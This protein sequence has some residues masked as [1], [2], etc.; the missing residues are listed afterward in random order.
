MHLEGNKCPN[1]GFNN[2][3]LQSNRAMMEI[4]MLNLTNLMQEDPESG[5]LSLGASAAG[6]TAGGGVNLEEPYE[7][8]EEHGADG[9]NLMD[10]ANPSLSAASDV[11]SDDSDSTAAPSWPP[12]P[13]GLVSDCRILGPE[14]KGKEPAETGRVIEG[15]ENLTVNEPS[16]AK[17]LFAGAPNTPALPNWRRSTSQATEDA[18]NLLSGRRNNFSTLDLKPDEVTNM[19]H[20]P[21]Q[22]C[23]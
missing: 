9:T 17:K 14:T 5:T 16:W 2:G 13:S 19:Y 11:I 7:L 23:P 8:L 21:F 3:I 6:D 12:R 22:N 10:S 1:N 4:H 15:L 18:S 20:C